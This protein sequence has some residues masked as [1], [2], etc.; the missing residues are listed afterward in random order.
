MALIRIQ[1]VIV[2]FDDNVSAAQTVDVISFSLDEGT[3]AVIDDTRVKSTA[4]RRVMGLPGGGTATLECQGDLDNTAIVAMQDAYSTSALR[5]LV[6]VYPSGTRD[7]L[8]VEA[9]VASITYAGETN[10]KAVF[11]FALELDAQIIIS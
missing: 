4:I 6:V 8:T 11:S 10:G 1:G 7:T 5:T 3:A 2:T 9:G